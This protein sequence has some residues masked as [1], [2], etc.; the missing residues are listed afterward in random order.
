[1]RRGGNQKYGTATATATATTAVHDEDVVV[2]ESKGVTTT[3]IKKERRVYPLTVFTSGL[4]SETSIYH[5]Q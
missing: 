5:G 4:M 1:M 3:R 2:V